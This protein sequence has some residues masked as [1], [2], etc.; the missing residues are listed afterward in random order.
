[1][2]A[3]LYILLLVGCI[4]SKPSL[5]IFVGELIFTH[6]IQL[7]DEMNSYKAV[8]IIYRYGT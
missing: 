3:I 1:M 8:I 7:A 5:F 2:Y 6:D 4:N